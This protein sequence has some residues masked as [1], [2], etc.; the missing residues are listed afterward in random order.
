MKQTNWP[1]WLPR[2][3]RLSVKLTNDQLNFI[4]PVFTSLREGGK[5]GAAVDNV[6]LCN[7]S[8][9]GLKVSLKHFIRRFAFSD[10]D[11]SNLTAALK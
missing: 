4:R 7:G 2:G 8:I 9:S 5:Y 11:T 1:H 6:T 10:I 3:A